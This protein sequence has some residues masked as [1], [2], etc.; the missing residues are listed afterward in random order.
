MPEPAGITTARTVAIHSPPTS[1]CEMGQTLGAARYAFFT[2]LPDHFFAKL[3]TI[4]VDLTGRTFL[5]T[6]S[7]TGL[8]LASAIQLA[9]MKPAHLILGV[10]DLSKGMKAKDEIIAQTNYAGTIDVWELDMARFDSVKSFA[11]KSAATLGRLDGAIINAG[12]T[13]PPRYIMSPDGWEMTNL[14]AGWSLSLQVNGIATG[15]LAVLLLP[16]LQVTTKLPPSH[17]D[18]HQT[19]PHLTITG[20]AGTHPFPI[21]LDIISESIKM[22]KDRYAISKLFNLFFAREIAALPQ[23]QGVVVN[24]V[25]P[26]MCVSDIG[27]DRK[28]GRFALWLYHTVAWPISKGAINMIYAALMPTPPGAFISSCEIR[29]PPAW[30]CKKEGLQLQKKVWDEMIEVWRGVAP[31]IDNIIR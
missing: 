9:R 19:P 30:T 24:V 18:A 2:F 21:H 5:V 11:E 25:D 20:S 13:S 27:R 17:P 26:G 7:N 31:E 29:S 8:G 15:L 23:A 4:D 12:I 6:G 22:S 14:D 16:L 10:R 28:L 3:P 1:T